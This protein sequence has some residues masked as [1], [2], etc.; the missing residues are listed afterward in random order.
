MT[1]G[2]VVNLLDHWRELMDD[3]PGE[4]ASA[5]SSIGF[6]ASV[7]ELLVP[8]TTGAVLHLVPDELR[9]TPRL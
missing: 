4:A 5:W 2:S 3:A 8:L 1:H 7:H 9:A 6:D